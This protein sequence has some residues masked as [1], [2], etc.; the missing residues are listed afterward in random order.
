MRSMRSKRTSLV[1]SVTVVPMTQPDQDPSASTQQFRAFANRA[2]AD[3]KKVNPALII[4]VVV[5]VAFGA[6]FFF[7]ALNAL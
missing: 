7:V 2:D 1:N 4:G 3:Q 5:A 6:L